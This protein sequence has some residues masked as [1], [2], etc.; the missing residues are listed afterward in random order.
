MTTIMKTPPLLLMKIGYNDEIIV[1]VGNKTST[2]CNDSKDFNIMLETT[3]NQEDALHFQ[4]KSAPPVTNTTKKFKP[5]KNSA[6]LLLEHKLL[7]GR[8][9]VAR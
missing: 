9:R 8:Q 1:F 4:E 5:T 7:A 2:E 3:S 6:V